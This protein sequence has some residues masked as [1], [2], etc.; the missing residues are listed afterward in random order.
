MLLNTNGIR[1]AQEPSAGTTIANE[2]MTLADQIKDGK[3]TP[4]AASAK[5]IA[6]IE[7]GTS[8]NGG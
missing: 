7:E 2:L 8:G 4:E 5:A 6:L 3:E 1:I